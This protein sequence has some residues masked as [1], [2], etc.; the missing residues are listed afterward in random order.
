M[1]LEGRGDGTTEFGV[2]E[3]RQR[4]AAAPKLRLRSS[5]EGLC[6]PRSKLKEKAGF[7]DGVSQRHSPSRGISSSATLSRRFSL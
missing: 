5:E 4:V 3:S 7:L 1:G 6:F 2:M